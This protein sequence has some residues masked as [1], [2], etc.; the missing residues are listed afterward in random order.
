TISWSSDAPANTVLDYGKT[1]AYGTNVTVPDPVTSHT[2]NLTGLTPGTTYHYRVQSTANGHTAASADLT[3]TTKDHQ[4]PKISAIVAP[5]TAYTTKPIPGTTDEPATS[6]IDYSTNT[7]YNLVASNG[8]LVTSHSLT[9][10]SLSSGTTYHFIVKGADA[11]G[12][13]AVTADQT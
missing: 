10:S 12:N 4:P 9:L 3:F 2:V 13:P 7:S 11:T 6:E 1:T 5:Q 8:T